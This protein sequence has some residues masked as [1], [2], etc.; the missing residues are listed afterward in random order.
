M[1]TVDRHKCGATVMIVPNDNGV[2]VDGGGICHVKDCC[3]LSV[4]RDVRQ[5]QACW[6]F[7]REG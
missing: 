4:C 7:R 1:T 6:L 5:F 2:W 3:E